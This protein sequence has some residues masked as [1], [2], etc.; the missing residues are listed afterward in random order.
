[1]EVWLKNIVLAFVL[2]VL[3]FLLLHLSLIY[4]TPFLLAVLLAGLLNPPVNLLAE[5]AGLERSLAAFLVLFLFTA[6]LLFFI[7]TGLFQ[8]YLELNKLL[9]SLPESTHILQEIK[10]LFL[11]NLRLLSSPLER[12][13]QENLELLYNTLKEGLLFLANNLLNILAKLPLVLSVVVLTLITTYFLTC[14]VDKINAFILTLFPER[15]RGRIHRLEKEI[16]NS[17]L[18]FLRAEL[19][20]MSVTGIITYLGLL[21]AGNDF[22]LLI[23]LTVALLDFIPLLGPGIVFV[24]WILF[25]I[26]TGKLYAGLEILIIYTLATAIRQGLEGKIMGQEMG[27]HPLPA[28]IAFY[29]ACRLSGPL[30]FITGPGT[31]LLWKAV[32]NSGLF[33]KQ[34]VFRE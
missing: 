11:E 10:I 23:A 8:I 22:A 15:Y 16:L 6:L 13:L 19:I 12:I 14:D 24:P 32:W 9:L 1:M 5:K 4:L 17:G 28:M 33:P 2:L 30:G 18:K 29:I 26:F 21:L 7:F 20:L 31:L 3:I 27:L 34:I 25:N